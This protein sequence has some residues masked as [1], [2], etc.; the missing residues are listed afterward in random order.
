MATEEPF[1]KREVGEWKCFVSESI[2]MTTESLKTYF[3]I[4]H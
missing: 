1:D 3:I 2:Q 4:S